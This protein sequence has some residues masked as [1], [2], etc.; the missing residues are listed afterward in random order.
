MNQ[1]GNALHGFSWLVLQMIVFVLA[2][3]LIGYTP[4]W[5][6]WKECPGAVV[7]SDERNADDVADGILREARVRRPGV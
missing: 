6:G 5:L 1:T 3:D 4:C 2:L 7:Q